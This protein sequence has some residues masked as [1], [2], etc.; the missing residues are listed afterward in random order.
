VAGFPQPRRLV[1]AV[2]TLRNDARLPGRLGPAATLGLL[3]VPAL[4]DA[5]LLAVGVV[6]FVFHR[7]RLREVWA[8]ADEPSDL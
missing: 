1:E 3:P 5:I 2:R 4:N 7:P 6:L 8:E